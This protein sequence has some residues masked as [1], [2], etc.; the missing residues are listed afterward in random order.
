M[1][2]RKI[3]RILVIKMESIEIENYVSVIGGRCGV[4]RFIGE[5]DFAQG[6]WFGIELD[7]PDGKNNGEL[8]G[9][10]YFV[11]PPNHGVFV[12]R[13]QVRHFFTCEGR[14]SLN[15]SIF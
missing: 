14:Y 7:T 5:T 8:N 12:R 4:V 15:L 11:C 3:D 1:N 13:A 10:T 9:R 2:I 6:E